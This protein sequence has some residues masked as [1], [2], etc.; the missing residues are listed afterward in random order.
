MLICSREGK[1]FRIRGSSG[2]RVAKNWS[3]ILEFSLELT[4]S[5]SIE[6]SRLTFYGSFVALKSR[7]GRQLPM[8]R[9]K[10]LNFDAMC[11]VIISNER[12]HCL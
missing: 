8:Q 7:E 10:L 5:I 9:L 2:R 3:Q 6:N 12:F 4:Q 1:E 11:L